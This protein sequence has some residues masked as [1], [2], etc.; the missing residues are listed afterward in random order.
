MSKQVRSLAA[1]TKSMNDLETQEVEKEFIG[2]IYGSHG[3]TKTTASQAL[4]QKL[5]GTGRILFL[6]SADGWVS[7]ENFP[8]LKRSTDL[9]QVSDPRELMVLANAI[10]T[11]KAPFKDTTV[12]VLDEVS[13]WFTD[14]LHM[15]VREATGTG[16]DEDLPEI[17]GSMY[18]GPQA[19][20][21]NLI[22]V[23]HKT[24]GLHVIMVAH[25]QERAVKGERGASKITPSLPPKLTSGLAQL[26]HV[27]ARFESVKDPKEK[28]GYR[29][30][31]QVQPTRYVEAKT[32]IG[33]LDVKVSV[34][35]LLK[36]VESWVE[37]PDL[38]A[39][40]LISE[41][42]QLAAEE[43]EDDEADDEED[44]ELSEDEG[45]EE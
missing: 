8:K 26:S 20:F 25:E 36:A 41:E 11:R 4:A 24:S 35:T 37:D 19:A 43:P 27:I 45:E 1:I 31:A 33:G 16:D 3:T 14:V 13:S 10:R 42:P 40:D 34:N 6:D 5:R 44:F 39:E 15:H 2:L 29:R 9:L 32:R 30:E 7:L 28:S 23:F 21:L 38:M 22:K 17:E 12:V 18:A